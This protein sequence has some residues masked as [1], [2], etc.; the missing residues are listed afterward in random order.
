M[1]DV[2][3]VAEE[4][5]RLAEAEQ[6]DPIDT[7]QLLARGRRGL[8][9]RRLLGAG[10]ALAGVAAIALAAS[11]LPNLGT[12]T[13]PLPV[14]GGDNSLFE[15]VPGVPRGEESAGQKL[16]A[17]EATRRCDLRYPVHKGKSLPRSGTYWSGRSATYS[18]R[19]DFAVC[20]VP[21]GDKPSAALIAAAKRDPMPTTAAGQLR[22]C[23]VQAWVDLTK[24][25]VVAV[26]RSTRLR[27]TMLI[28]VSPTGRKA[29]A[30]QLDAALPV[31]GQ[32]FNNSQFLTLGSLDE[33]DPVTSAGKGSKHADL[34]AGGGGGGGFCPERSCTKNYFFTGWGRVASN[35]TTVKLQMGS[36]P[37]HVVPVTDGWFALTYV[38]KADHSTVKNPPTITAYDKRGKVVKV[39]QR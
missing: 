11:F 29:I 34:F 23:S 10:G 18:S 12:S 27:T 17:E 6:Q 35:A 14:A 20:I 4:L 5:H 13:E 32:E 38:S 3:T 2:R 28:A 31:S 25:H 33:N 36:D 15:P 9:R 26:D 39:V 7:A 16:T 8:R 1:D 30:C 37:A 24:W 21:G 22:N 19:G